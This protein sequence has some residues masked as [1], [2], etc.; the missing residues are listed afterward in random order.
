MTRTQRLI[1]GGGV[2]ASMIGGGAAGAAIVTALNSPAAI[3]LAA[4]NTPASPNPNGKFVPNEDPAHEQSESAAREA[5]EDAGQRPT[6][7]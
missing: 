2:L 7:P 6:I 5:Q 4:T 1:V 3:A